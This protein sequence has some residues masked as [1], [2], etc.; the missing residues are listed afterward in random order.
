METKD[1]GL[2]LIGLSFSDD[3]NVICE[4]V[5]D[6]YVTVNIL[7]FMSAMQKKFEGTYIYIGEDPDGL[8][9]LGEVK[10]IKVY[11]NRKLYCVQL[12]CTVCTRLCNKNDIIHKVN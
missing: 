3:G 2:N 5:S 9:V 8:V 6:T 4:L 1:D 12:K 11:I 7:K 10:N